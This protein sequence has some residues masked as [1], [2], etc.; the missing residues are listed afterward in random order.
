[1]NP[2][3]KML[4]IA[5]SVLLTINIIIINISFVLKFKAFNPDLYISLLNKY[6]VYSD[7]KN[8]LQKKLV[9]AVKDVNIPE[10]TADNVITTDWV[11]KQ[12]ENIIISFSGVYTGDNY[13]I[14]NI[15]TTEPKQN[16]ANNLSK[17]LPKAAIDKDSIRAQ[18]IDNL[19]NL[20]SVFKDFSNVN[21]SVNL[22]KTITFFYSYFY[23]FI[24]S[25]AVLL[26]LCWIT[27]LNKGTVFKPF[28]IGGMI[29]L[30]PALICTCIGSNAYII[31]KYFKIP[32]ASFLSQTHG[33]ALFMGSILKIFGIY[34]SILSASFTVFG[35]ILCAIF[36]KAYEAKKPDLFR[37][38]LYF[39]IK[40]NKKTL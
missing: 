25:F 28:I 29:C 18:E 26:V 35:S 13:D 32:F 3:R 2:L 39:Q 24:I 14:P 10:S 23:I 20:D 37:I 12:Y 40:S 6:S 38:P 30:I 34:V 21:F 11:K 9:R 8:F 33:G 36:S 16:F 15:D 4:L 17:V 1:M 27:S 5:L 19:Y 22:K 31:V 7:T